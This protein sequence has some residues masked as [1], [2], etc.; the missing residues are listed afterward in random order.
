L[1]VLP[2]DRTRYLVTDLTETALTR[3]RQRFAGFDFVD[4]AILDLD[5]D[6]VE[7]GLTAGGSDLVVAADSLHLARVLSAALGCLSTLLVPGGQ[8][9]IAEQ[10][11]VETLLPFLG[12]REEFWDFTDEHVRPHSP[13]LSREGWREVLAEAGYTEIVQ[14]GDDDECAAGDFSVM[15]AT[16]K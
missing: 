16:A 7:Q 11:R 1:P 15:L 14:V 13:L 6:P 9:L 12:V 8:L 5:A 3:L 4:H 10:H 2:A